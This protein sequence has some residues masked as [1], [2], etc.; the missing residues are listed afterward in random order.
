LLD[1]QLKRV[2]KELDE[3]IATH[4]RSIVFIHGVGNG[5]LRQEVRRVIAGYKNVRFHDASFRRYGFG[6]TEVEII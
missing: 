6:A 3:A 1:I 2:V 4:I 5:R